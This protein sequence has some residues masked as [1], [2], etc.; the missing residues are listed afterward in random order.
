T[1][2]YNLSEAATVKIELQQ[3]L[4][5]RKKGKA[6]VKPTAKLSKAKKCVRAASQ[7]TLTRTSHAGANAVAFSGRVGSRALK[8][9]SY[10]AVLTAT[11]AAR[12][13][14]ARKTLAFKVVR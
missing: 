12:N 11:D 3:L 7:G 1:F 13:V 10:Q 9:G 14:S 2:K 4:P 6:C 8:P 5:G